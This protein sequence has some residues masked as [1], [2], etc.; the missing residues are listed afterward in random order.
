MATA[1]L[2]GTLA[3][4]VGRSPVPVAAEGEGTPAAPLALRSI[5]VGSE[6]AC[7]IDL[8]GRVKCWGSGGSG[9]LGLGDTANRGDAG[10]E[11][12]NALPAVDLGTGRTATSISAGSVHTCALLDDAQVKCWGNNAQGRLGLG[13]ANARG[14]AAGEM[15]DSLP[16]VNLG[17]GRT[18]VA[19]AAA[20]SHT[21]ALLDNAQVKCWGNNA[22]GQL[23]YGDTTARGDNAGEMGNSLPAVDLG[24]GQSVRAVTVGVGF[25]CA[26]LTNGKVKCWGASNV[27]QLGYG[28]TAA[29]GN[30]P[31]EMGVDL[32]AVD[33]GR[34]RT[35]QSLSSGDAHTCAI[36]DDRSLRCW[37]SGGVGRLGLGNTA[38]RGDGPDEM[39]DA[40]PAVDLGPGRVATVV[41]AGE[42]HSCA[43]LD[44]ATVKCWGNNASG[45][46][47]QGNTTTR[48]DGANEMGN[49][50]AASSLGTGATPLA[51]DAGGSTTCVRLDDRRIKCWGE[52]QSGRLG[53]GDTTD[54]GDNAG[55]MGDNLPAV[56]VAAR[57]PVLDIESG[58][59]TCVLLQGG[60]VRC[61]GLNGS[62]QLGLGDTSP[63]GDGGN[64]MGDDLPFV[65]LGS[66]ERAEAI[67]VGRE[68]AC[69]L[70]AGG[71]VKCW[72]DN[73][74]G[75]L[76]LGDVD[77]RGDAPGELGD[78]L[79]AVALGSGRTATAV[80]AGR[81]HT[82]ALLD[83]GQVKCWGDNFTGQLGL[84]D[85]TDR[86]DAPGEM[87]DA[88]PAVNLGTGR[89][90]TAIWAGNRRTC[91]RLDNSTLKCWGDGVAGL[92]GL[93][94]ATNRGD[95]PG[96]MGDA[97]PPVDLG[98]GRTVVDLATGIQHNC[99]LLDNATIKCWGFNGNGELG[100][101]DGDS[102]GDG[103]GEMGNALPAVDLG[104]GRTATSIA[105]DDAIHTCATL[106]DGTLKCWGS[107]NLG[108]L[109]LGATG[110]RGLLPS[111]MGDNLPAVDVGTGRRA[112]AATTGFNTTCALLDDG[113]VRCWGFNSQ[114]Q[115][116]LG[117]TDHR[118]DNP[119][120]MGDAL[121]RVDTGSEAPAGIAG[122]VRTVT[123]NAI[124]VPGA[125]VAA[126]RTTDFA[127]AGGT[128]ADAG[129][130]YVL[131]APPGTYFVYVI[132]PAARHTSGFFGDPTTRT[133]DDVALVDADPALP[134]L[135]GAIAGTIDE[136][137]FNDPLTEAWGLT[138]TGTGAPE[139]AD[140]VDANGAFVVP[141]L[142]TGN[143][144][145][146]YVDGT[147]E[148]ATEFYVNS[149]NV[150][151][152]TP[153]AVFA[154]GAT[155]RN[156]S[157]APQTPS[158]GGAALTG[159]VTSD[160]GAPLADVMV[161][162]MHAAD[163]R[164]ARIGATDA[165]GRYDL[166][167]PAGSY[168]LVF[169]DPAGDHGME[170]FDNQP[171]FGIA[172]AANFTV[173]GNHTATLTPT[174]GSISGTVTD[175]TSGA[176][177]AAAWVLAIAAN[178]SLTG[179]PTEANGTYAITGLAPGT[180][181][182]TFVDPAGGR[183]QE[184]FDDSPDY[185]GGTDLNVTAGS[186]TPFVNAA[187]S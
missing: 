2:A 85:N 42:A 139:A 183:A 69:A 117:D 155:T 89:T 131:E 147:G 63:R 162:A 21:C 141:D 146:A 34:G 70:L 60:L 11:M 185:F 113:S 116:G 93:G 45:Q 26:L 130:R 143:H 178:G 29:L 10:G 50:L 33:L 32:P 151:A 66:G 105:L 90:A 108:Q 13:D 6:H 158:P 135:R 154:G 5:A 19:I 67:A 35:V 111:H 142:V 49:A 71:A 23:G 156:A 81:A 96:E 170:W 163:F 148:H 12:G 75:R 184:Y 92:L 173:P 97:L 31:G 59:M 83:N 68:H 159:R 145:L 39:G 174:G 149:P 115:L 101:G 14:D 109:G 65:P 79:P 104:T 127:V 37:G 8:A 99:A 47:G 40:L 43:V 160:S 87:G 61:W 133:V 153:V 157:L 55:E 118:G 175:A 164:L 165:D 126:L 122:T 134:R 17:T 125:F 38:N 171:Y 77:D 27:G 144:F 78:T 112:V 114:G 161:I 91:A 137:Q 16:A 80:S 152:A 74:D 3:L 62:G 46:L 86:G 4:A 84:G 15:G 180:Y 53:L 72:G 20:G 123:P 138:L 106:D 176:P 179:V 167:L 119:G 100:L 136:T 181:R 103:P 52:N 82:C 1:L 51:V 22:S 110:G 58:G 44:N 107:N 88:L 168:K 166:D 95:G 64:E 36:L 177:L 54:R 94:D 182:L 102:R 120:E 172:D 41:T 76:G 57:R 128:V 73:G 7:G 169:F 25:S 150:P 132:D 98:T 24:P 140:P 129:G 56:D 187:L 30:A 28:G 9:R 121:P 18:A 48:G 124:P 186:S